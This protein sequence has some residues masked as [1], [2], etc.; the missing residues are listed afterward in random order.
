MASIGQQLDASRIHP[1]KDRILVT[2]YVRP[3]MTPSGLH[4]PAAYRV[5]PAWAYWE[6]VAAGPDCERQ[7]GIKLG[8]GD[9]IRTPFRPA[10]DLGAEDAS[11]NRLFIV[12]AE[13]VN[14]VIPCTWEVE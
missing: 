14:G 2:K 13:N 11:G 8:P 9:I 10:I 7:L 5:D 12:P 3:D 4:I 6:V 1:T